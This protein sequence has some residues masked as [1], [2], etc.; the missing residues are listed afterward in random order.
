MSPPWNTTLSP[1]A[2]TKETPGFNSTS[3]VEVGP[4]I[5]TEAGLRAPGAG[6]LPPC[7]APG[8][9]VTGAALAV[10]EEP[11]AALSA[12]GP[13]APAAVCAAIW[14]ALLNAIGGSKTP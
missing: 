7:E 6:L 12:T 10:A 11:G 5:R 3:A 2:R 13:D 14:E 9:T 8:A 1:G 4:A